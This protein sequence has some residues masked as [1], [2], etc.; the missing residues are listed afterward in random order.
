LDVAAIRSSWGE[1]SRS[2]LLPGITSEIPQGNPKA[3]QKKRAAL[4][5]SA[6]H[7]FPPARAFTIRL[8]LLQTLPLFVD[9]SG[10]SNQWPGY[11]NRVRVRLARLPMLM[12]ALVW[13]R[14]R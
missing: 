3:R 11:G 8:L 10:P 14:G 5:V 12:A 1:F 4:V 6:A 9:F 2:V 13:A 7:F